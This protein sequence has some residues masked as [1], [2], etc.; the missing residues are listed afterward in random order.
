MLEDLDSVDWKNLGH[1]YGE[2]SDVPDLIRALASPAKK[3]R[4][5]AWHHLYSNVWH[6]GT[7]YEATA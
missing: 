7:V 2:A 5:D 3:S 4:E 1:A 6:Q